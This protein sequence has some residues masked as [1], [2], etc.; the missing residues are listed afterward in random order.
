MKLALAVLCIAAVAF[1]LRVLFALIKDAGSSSHL[2]H[3]FYFAR[4]VPSERRTELIR[5]DPARSRQD[6][7]VEADKRIA[8]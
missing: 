8:S 2:K 7:S 1:L 6:F 4:F 5:L 3:R